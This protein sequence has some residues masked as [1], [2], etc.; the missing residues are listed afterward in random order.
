M[1]GFL[2]LVCTF[3]VKRRVLENTSSKQEQLGNSLC[4]F[5]ISSR[6]FNGDILAHFSCFCLIDYI[7]IHWIIFAVIYAYIVA[8]LNL[9]FF[10]LVVVRS[11]WCSFPLHCLLHYFYGLLL[12]NTWTFYFDISSKFGLHLTIVKKILGSMSLNM[13]KAIFFSI[14]LCQF[15]FLGAAF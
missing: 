13:S 4:N 12:T 3:W 15:S 14:F 8:L 6:R 10:L 9:T 11:E 5:V 7:Y 1:A 2:R